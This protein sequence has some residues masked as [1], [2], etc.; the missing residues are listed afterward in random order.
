MEQILRVFYN[1]GSFLTF[2]ALQL[3]SVYLIV[4]FNSEQGDI[5]AETWALRAGSVRSATAAVGDYMDLRR[6]NADQRARIAEL[7][8]QLPTSA[9]DTTVDVDSFNDPQRLQR[10]NFLAATVV[11]RSPYGPNNTLV[12]DKGAKLGVAVGQGVVGDRGLIGVVDRVTDNYARLLSVLHQR[13]RVSAGLRGGGYGTLR[14]DG[15]DP[16]YM[17]L[18]DLPDYLT[19]NPGDT[20]F[21]TGYSNLYPTGHAIGTVESSEVQPGTGSQHLRVRLLTDPL[22]TESAYVV[23]DLF[24]EELSRL[25][26]R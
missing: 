16:R 20:L 7:R 18:T 25:H 9:Y 24:K 26:Q 1:N 17:T 11:N 8:G 23:H 3:V 22:R 15:L 19:V 6:V 14:W 21:T 2:L 5:A 4:N 13:T 12:I 10:F